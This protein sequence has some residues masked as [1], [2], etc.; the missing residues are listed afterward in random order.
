MNNSVSCNIGSCKPLR[1]PVGARHPVAQSLRAAGH[2]VPRQGFFHTF[3]ALG[4]RVPCYRRFHAQELR[5][6]RRRATQDGPSPADPSPE[7]GFGP[8]GEGS[9]RL[10]RTARYGPRPALR[11]RAFG[12]RAV[13]SAEGGRQAGEGSVANSRGAEHDNVT[14]ALK[15]AGSAAILPAFRAAIPRTVRAGCPRCRIFHRFRVPVGRRA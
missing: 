1:I 12:R 13:A 5:T 11:P 10:R 15:I 14:P 4:E 3:S 6:V 2:G 9:C 7:G 8:Q